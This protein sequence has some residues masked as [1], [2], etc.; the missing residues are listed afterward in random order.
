[1]K[2]IGTIVLL[3][4]GKEVISEATS[5]SW[6]DNTYSWSRGEQYVKLEGPDR[7]Y[8]EQGS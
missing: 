8:G 6:V 2:R 4:L 7:L 1:M 3:R 5:A